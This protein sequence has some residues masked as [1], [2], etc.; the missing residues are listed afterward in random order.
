MDAHSKGLI[1]PKRWHEAWVDRRRAREADRHALFHK[2]PLSDGLHLP[3]HYRALRWALK[4][5]RL[6]ARG[7]RNYTDIRITPITHAIE[8]WPPPLDGFRILQLSDLHIDLDPALLPVILHRLKGLEYELAVVTG[9]FLESAR[10]DTRPAIDDLGR[11]LEQI[12]EPPFGRFGVL[13]NHDSLKLAAEL[14]SMGLSVLVNEARHLGSGTAGFALAGVDD[15]YFFKTDDLASAADRCPEA[16]PRILL[17]HSPQLA[18]AAREAGF[19]LMLSGHTHGGQICLPG[20]HAILTMEEIP[21]PLFRGP[22]RQGP[23]SGYTT[24][25]TGACH[26]PVR[27]N[28]PPEI[29]LHTLRPAGRLTASEQNP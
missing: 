14:E 25:G 27:F 20:G 7:Y 29:V 21:R 24:T 26:L 16:I 10:T 18:P 1:L 11:L 15:A 9:D 23:L 22:W 6:Y 5:A 3:F 2:A 4:A 8:G 12:G 28:C 17:S 13:G 19:A